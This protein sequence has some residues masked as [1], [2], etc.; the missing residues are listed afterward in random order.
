[1]NKK[2]IITAI[3]TS[4]QLFVAAGFT[5]QK[6]NAEPNTIAA[7]YPMVTS[8]VLT[9]AKAAELSKGIALRAGDI[10]ISMV[11]IS[12][13]IQEQPPELQDELNKNALFVLEHLATPRL[14][15]NLAKKS[16]TPTAKEADPIPDQQIIQDYFEKHVF[17]NIEVTDAEAEEFYRQNKNMFGGATLAQ[18]REQIKPYLLGQK[19]Q[20]AAA[21]Y[22]RTVGKKIDISVSAS[23][24][25]KQAALTLGNPVD[26]ARNSG[27]PSLADFGATGCVPCDMLAPILKDL[28]A[29]Y[30]DKLNVLFVHVREKQ[31]LAARYG[32]E[33]IPVQ[34]F[35][36]KS[37]KEVFRHVGFWPQAEIEKKLTE[38]GVK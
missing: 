6:E 33:T 32:V 30:K 11:D 29:K 4:L 8:G 14:L 20:K 10:T 36:D 22:I 21:D 19:K 38:M 37:G 7:L 16:T 1:M 34:I 3:C 13:F 24:L 25:K 28:E 35:F 31:I 18:V 5:Q 23:W 9:F 15:L 17:S 26:K 12:R 27:K 2:C